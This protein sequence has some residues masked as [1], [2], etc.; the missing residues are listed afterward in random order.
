MARANSLQGRTSQGADADAARVRVLAA[1]KDF[2]TLW[3]NVDP[4]IPS[5]V[6]FDLVRRHQYGRAFILNQEHHEFRR[7][8]LACILP[9]DVN[10]I[11]T[12]IEGLTGCQSHFFSSAQLHHDGALQ[13]INKRMRV[14][15]MY[16]V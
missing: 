2:L 3:K 8:G 5:L 1:Y 15:A 16:W 14:V 6:L 7:F 13:D 11:G 12:F 4:D 9:D 10:I